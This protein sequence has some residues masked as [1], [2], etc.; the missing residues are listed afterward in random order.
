MKSL[1]NRHTDLLVTVNGHYHTIIIS[2]YPRYPKCS[3]SS[4]RLRIHNNNT[5][6]HTSIQHTPFS[7]MKTSSVAFL[8]VGT[9][10]FVAE[11]ILDVRI[12]SF[13]TQDGSK[14]V[15]KHASS[16]WTSDITRNAV[17]AFDL[18]LESMEQ[19]IDISNDVPTQ[20][21]QLQVFGIGKLKEFSFWGQNGFCKAIQNVTVPDDAVA[22]TPTV[23]PVVVNFTFG[24]KQLFKNSDLGTGNWV[25]AF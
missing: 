22:I 4:H 14:E 10:I 19:D 20:S 24:C 3:T 7:T 16:D 17:A 18:E 5:T 11:L 1:A 8:S 15:K 12:S 25:S 9:I 23:L 21:P 13:R 6:R 2:E